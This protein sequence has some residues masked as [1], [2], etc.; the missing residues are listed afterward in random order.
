M[1]S[2]SVWLL[3]PARFTDSLRSHASRRGHQTVQDKLD[4]PFDGI[5]QD[6]IDLHLITSWTPSALWQNPDDQRIPVL[7]ATNQDSGHC[8]PSFMAKSYNV[9]KTEPAI[10]E[11]ALTPPPNADT[12]PPIMRQPSFSRS[13]LARSLHSRSSLHPRTPDATPPRD[14]AASAGEEGGGTRPSRQ[15]TL[16]KDDDV[17]VQ[18]GAA[19]RGGTTAT[20]QGGPPMSH[21]D[22]PGRGG[23]GTQSPAEGSIGVLPTGGVPPTGAS[24]A[25]EETQQQLAPPPSAAVNESE[26]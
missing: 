13:S 9:V 20:T 7:E 16:R 5:G 25:V 12:L 15:S 24:P 6:D 11:E 17:H 14:R 18:A 4:D 2:G 22:V 26:V 19:A 23:E 21:L 8:C 10:D 3:P 1:F